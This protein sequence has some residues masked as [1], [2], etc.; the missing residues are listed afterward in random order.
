MQSRPGAIPGMTGI[1]EC[2][3]Q[4]ARLAATPLPVGPFEAD[5]APNA[6]GASAH[7]AGGGELVSRLLSAYFHHGKSPEI[8]SLFP[9]S[10][11]DVPGWEQTRWEREPSGHTRAVVPLPDT[12]AGKEIQTSMLSWAITFLII[13]LIAGVLG[14]TGVAGV[15]SHIAWILFVVFL[16]LFLVSLLTGR[17][18]PRPLA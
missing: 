15:S 4:A 12:L 3:F 1:A 10:W 5:T 17:R 18:G 6:R 11:E 13:A 14:F 2:T 16:V 9:D 8:A 7:R